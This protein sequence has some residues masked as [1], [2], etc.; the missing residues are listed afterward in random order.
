MTE[1]QRRDAV[2]VAMIESIG[3]IL[4]RLRQ[5]PAVGDLTQAEAG[6][7]S[8]LRKET[9]ST[10]AEL[11]RAEDVRPQ[12][13]GATIAALEARGLVTRHHDDSDGRRVLLTLTDEGRKI[14]ERK[15]TARSEQFARALTA[16]GFTDE[17]LET[18]ASAAP[19][20]DRL[21]RSLT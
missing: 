5:L 9:T 13:M 14:S 20:I 4:R 7:L 16:G 3:L 11:A 21:A 18:L 17:E 10:S 2:A 15:H 19:L 12:T 1:T 8:R 6:V